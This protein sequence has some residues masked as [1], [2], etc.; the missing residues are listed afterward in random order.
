MVLSGIHQN[1]SAVAS[2]NVKF[3]GNSEV[4]K[5]DQVPYNHH[6]LLHYTFIVCPSI[7]FVNFDNE[8]SLYKFIY[9]GSLI[10]KVV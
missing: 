6:N 7:S 1:S 8:F 2:R 9:S 5:L 4:L 3:A 10:I